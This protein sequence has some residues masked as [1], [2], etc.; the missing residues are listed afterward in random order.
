MLKFERVKY[1]TT[2]EEEELFYEVPEYNGKKHTIY[3]KGSHKKLA[4]LTPEGRLFIW[5][6]YSWDLCSPKYDIYFM[7]NYF[8]RIGVV[9]KDWGTN[10]IWGQLVEVEFLDLLS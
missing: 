10:E 3:K 4:E 9:T 7:D 6:G 5:K 8:G 1:I 2:V